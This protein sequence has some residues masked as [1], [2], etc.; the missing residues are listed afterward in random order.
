MNDE[1]MINNLRKTYH[2]TLLLVII[3]AIILKY[4]IGNELLNVILCNCILLL[5]T[6]ELVLNAILKDTKEIT[7]LSVWYALILINLIIN[8]FKI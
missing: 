5:I 7:R 1:K 8:L 4:S 2:N 6:V 3:A